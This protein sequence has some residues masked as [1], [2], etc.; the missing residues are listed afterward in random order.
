MWGNSGMIEGP[1]ILE[2]GAY[3]IISLIGSAFLV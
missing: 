3:V 1:I 2:E